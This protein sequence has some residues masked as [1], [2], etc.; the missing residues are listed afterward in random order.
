MIRPLTLGAAISLF[1]LA[2][3]L[4]SFAANQAPELYQAVPT[5]TLASGAAAAPLTLSNYLRDPDV[6]GTAV[7]VSVR[8]GSHTISHSNA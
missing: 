3:R 5:L 1:L 6:P 7:R 4:V 2:G 8:L